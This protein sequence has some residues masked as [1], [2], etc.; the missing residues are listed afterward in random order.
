MNK[1]F[2]IFLFLANVLYGQILPITNLYHI[3]LNSQNNPKIEKIEF[4]NNF[5][6]NSYNNQPYFINDD[7]IYCTIKTKYSNSTDI[8]KFN[9]KDK[10]IQELITTE[11]N[12]YSPRNIKEL[13][14]GITC[15]HVNPN[16]TVQYL[17]QYNDLTNQTYEILLDHP[18]QVGYYRYYGNGQWI[19]FLVAQPN[20]LMAIV[21]NDTK[22]IFA[23]NIGRTFEIEANKDILFV[24]K[25]LD[26]KW[27]LKSYKPST[28]EMLHIADLPLKSEDFVILKNGE[29][30]CSSGSQILILNKVQKTW[31]SYLDFSP[32]GIMNIGRFTIKNNRIILVNEIK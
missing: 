27:I 26:D 24:H 4:L 13:G 14:N 29:I 21:S 3:E 16:D 28:E 6:L 15:V 22:K 19:C 7:E 17:V 23:S 10:T 8:Y 20:N 9:L 18:G 11:A 1:I 5:N 32:W 25:I 31:Q 2:L 30:L 12:D